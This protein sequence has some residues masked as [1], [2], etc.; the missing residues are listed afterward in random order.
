MHRPGTVNKKNSK[1]FLQLHKN[2]NLKIS[3]IFAKQQKSPKFL[4]F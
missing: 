1:D 3:Y 2:S 4:Y